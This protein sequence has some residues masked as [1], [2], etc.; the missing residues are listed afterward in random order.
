MSPKVIRDEFSSKKWTDQKKYRFRRLR[1]G[2][3]MHCGQPR[4]TETMCEACA[5][6]HRKTA[7]AFRLRRREVDHDFV[8]PA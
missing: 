7:V 1:D 6:K 2:L 5:G 8:S 4:K 3:C